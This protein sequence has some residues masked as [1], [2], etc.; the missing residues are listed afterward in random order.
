MAE[1]MR[2]DHEPN[3]GPYRCKDPSHAPTGEAGSLPGPVL[4]GEE[5]PVF[6]APNGDPRGQGG[7]GGVGEGEE[8]FLGPALPE[9]RDGP[10]REV[11]VRQVKGHSL[12]TAEAEIVEK[13]DQGLVP[14]GLWPRLGGQGVQK[15]TDTTTAW[16]AS[17]PV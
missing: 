2:T 7:A 10:G 12:A 11:N 17:V 4:V 9:D 16:S 3:L 6:L 1:T 15:T 13:T 14:P 5:S 8:F